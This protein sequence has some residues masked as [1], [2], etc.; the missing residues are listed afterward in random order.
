MKSLA[1]RHLRR[2]VAGFAWSRS[3]RFAGCRFW[4]NVTGRAS[5]PS[6]HDAFVCTYRYPSPSRR[7]GQS[8]LA[9]PSWNRQRGADT[10]PRA[11]N[12][13]AY[14]RTS[15]PLVGG[16]A[17]TLTTRGTNA[18][19][20]N[21]LS[22]R[23]SHFQ[24]LPLATKARISTA[25]SSA[26]WLAVLPAKS[27]A[28]ANASPAQ[29]SARPPALS[30]TTSDPRMTNPTR[31]DLGGSL[32]SHSLGIQPKSRHDRNTLDAACCVFGR[33][34]P[35]IIETGDCRLGGEAQNV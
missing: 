30:R 31:H 15:G 9:R 17:I 33:G 8:L 18:C 29:R 7:S 23:S 22:S 14:Q 6:K 11:E 16:K 19:K 4:C 24:A 32:R 3:M 13:I 10:R 12:V 2:T 35:N 26:D 25:Q 20:R 28:T 21:S 34:T 1:D 27:F 5:P